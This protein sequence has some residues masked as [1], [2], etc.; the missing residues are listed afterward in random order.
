M[1]ERVVSLEFST[2]QAARICGMTYVRLDSWSRRGQFFTASIRES[3]GS[4]TT[5]AYSF[6]DLVE[7][8]AILKFRVAGLSL[9]SLRKA[10]RTMD[11]LDLSTPWQYLVSLENGDIALLVGQDAVMSLLSQPGQYA[12]RVV[13]VSEVVEEVEEKAVVELAKQP[14]KPSQETRI[15]SQIKRLTEQLE[16]IRDEAQES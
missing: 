8:T 1:D 14:R 2:A 15:I 5:R 9:Q 3:A 11:E 16:T 4:G 12:A 13:N 7:I 10:K 6:K